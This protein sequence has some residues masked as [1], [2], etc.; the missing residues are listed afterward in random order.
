MS[1]AGMQLVQFSKQIAATAPGCRNSQLLVVGYLNGPCIRRK[2]T[3]ATI[4]RHTSPS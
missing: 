3:H 2:Q 4:Q 1:H